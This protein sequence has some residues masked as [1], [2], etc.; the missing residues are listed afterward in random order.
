M[1]SSAPASLVPPVRLG[2]I[3]H[4][5]RLEAGESIDALVRRCGLAYESEFFAAVESGEAAL[6]EPTVR[7]L[8]ALYDLRVEQLVPQRARL[9]IDL[10]EGS[11]AMGPLSAYLVDPQPD[12]V[13]AKYLA[14]VI[15]LRGL[16]VG[17]AL[18][19]R[20][21]DL[22]VLANALTLRP[23]DV[24]QRLHALMRGD[25]EPIDGAR[26]RLRSRVIVP[27]AG[28]LV[29]FTAVGALLFERASDSTSDP[30]VTVPVA[31]GSGNGVALDTPA[32]AGPASAG[33]ATPGHVDIG[34]PAVLV[35]PSGS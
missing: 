5:A 33:A 19:I 30:V 35:R 7:W 3:L 28:I 24:Q 22:D 4:D 29:A 13:L 8:A 17:A 21:L 20:D 6:D 15:E 11:V 18:K 9:V 34:E 14:L 1:V 16:P 12:D 25:P 26:R 2:R 32:A 27:M 23:R 10:N 31:V